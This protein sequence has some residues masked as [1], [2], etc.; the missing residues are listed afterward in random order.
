MTFQKA[1]EKFQQFEESGAPVVE[2]V[3]LYSRG[4]FH[5]LDFDLKLIEGS[6]AI[7]AKQVKTQSV[8]PEPTTKKRK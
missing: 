5:T 1:Q 4:S 6:V 3:Q 7:V 2:G 8:K